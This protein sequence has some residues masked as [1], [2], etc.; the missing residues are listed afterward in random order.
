ME[1]LKSAEIFVYLKE[2]FF[3]FSNK[4]M[5]TLI[6]MISDL[7]YFPEKQFEKKWETIDGNRVL[8]KNRFLIV[9]NS[10]NKFLE[11]GY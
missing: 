10:Q 4:R 11:G 5:N 2:A 7:L 1:T 3:F 8:V 9:K 6:Q